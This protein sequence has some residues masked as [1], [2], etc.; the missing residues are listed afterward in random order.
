MLQE[1]EDSFLVG[2]GVG[3]PHAY[4]PNVSQS[5][6]LVAKLQTPIPCGHTGSE[7][8]FIFLVISPEGKPKKHL[9]ALS[10]ISRFIMNDASRQAMHDAETSEDL[11]R[12]L[13]VGR[14]LK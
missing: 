4:T 12:L 14:E 1:A 6:V 11:F 10:E 7:M 13:A 2:Y 3:L 5:S 9:S 8:R